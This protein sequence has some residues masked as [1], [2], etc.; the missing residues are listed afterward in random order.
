MQ[1]HIENF[2]KSLQHIMHLSKPVLIE[3]CLFAICAVEVYKFF[4]ESVV[5]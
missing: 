5:E 2:I 1:L 3:L 4:I